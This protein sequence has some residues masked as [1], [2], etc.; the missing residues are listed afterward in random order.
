MTVD[1][2]KGCVA[3][4]TTFGLQIIFRGNFVCFDKI[5]NAFRDDSGERFPFL[6]IQAGGGTRRMDPGGK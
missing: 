6:C 4:V 1:L 5:G 2:Q 3:V